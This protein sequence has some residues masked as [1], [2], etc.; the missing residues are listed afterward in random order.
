MID[1]GNKPT[2]PVYQF[3]QDNGVMEDLHS[4]TA[5]IMLRNFIKTCGDEFNIKP[6]EIGL[7]LM[8][9]ASAM[10]MYLNAIPVFTI[11]LLGRWSSDVSATCFLLY[12]ACQQGRP[13]LPQPSFRR[14]K[15]R[16]GRKRRGAFKVWG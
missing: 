4:K 5:L 12:G 9:S 10:A 16:N 14:C 15:F 3:R 8:R 6:D 11:M 1:D 2:D 7:H 13:M